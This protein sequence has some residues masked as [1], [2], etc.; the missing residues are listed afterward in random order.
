MKSEPR[1]ARFHNV[2]HENSGTDAYHQES[3]DE[4][5]EH[6]MGGPDK[7]LRD[8]V[9]VVGVLAIVMLL[10]TGTGSTVGLEPDRTFR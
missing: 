1:C 8:I 2:P 10:V 3:N 4:G 6:R 5:K 7:R 9:A